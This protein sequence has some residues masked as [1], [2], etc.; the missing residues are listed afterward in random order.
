MGCLFF[1]GILFHNS[2]Q[3]QETVSTQSREAL[4]TQASHLYQQ[5]QFQVAQVM[6]TSLKQNSPKEDEIWLMSNYFGLICNLE[7]ERPQAAEKLASF[8]EKNPV[9][10]FRTEAEL[11][12][13]IEAYEKSDYPN[14]IGWFT[15]LDTLS[16]T[17]E[18]KPA[19]HYYVGYSFFKMD[20]LQKAKLSFQKIYHIESDYQA[21]AIYYYSL[22]SYWDNHLQN[23]LE[24]FEKLL[25]EFDYDELL[26]FYIVNIK[27]K[28]KKYNLALEEALDLIEKVKAKKEAE[29]LA[30][31]EARK[32]NRKKKKAKKKKRRKRTRKKNKSSGFAITDLELIAGQCYYNLEEYQKAVSYLKNQK[33]KN[34]YRQAILN[35]QLGTSFFHLK[36][37]KSALT[38][39]KKLGDQYDHFSQQAYYMMGHS[40]IKQAKKK[41]A[42]K[43]FRLAVKLGADST[44]IEEAKYN[45][46]KLSY[47]VGNPYEPV[48]DLIKKYITEHPDSPYRNEMRNMLL[49]H[50]MSTQDYYKSLKSLEKF[51]TLDLEEKIAYQRLLFHYGIELYQQAQLDSALVYLTKV[52]LMKLYSDYNDQ[53]G[54]WIGDILMQKNKDYDA[55]SYF[56]SYLQ[57]A[58]V[59]A[60]ELYEYAQYNIG[61]IYFKKKDYKKA[62]KAFD[63]FI[64]TAK[65]EKLRNDALLRSADSKFVL[66]QYRQAIRTYQK[67]GQL[68]IA[69]SD[70]AYYQMALCY[71]LLNKSKSQI[72]SLQTLA[73][74]FKRSRYREKVL[75][76]LAEVLG[77]K[78]R[79]RE[80]V[81]YYKNLIDDYPTGRYSER[82][83]LQMAM[84]M[85]NQNKLKDA[86]V[87]LKQIVSEKQNTANRKQAL[88]L[89]KK[90]YLLQNRISEY[91]TWVKSNQEVQ[92]NM[93][94]LDSAAYE[95]LE[96]NYLSQ[97]YQLVLEGADQYLKNFPKG[98][99]IPTVLDYATTSAGRLQNDSLI[100]KYNLLYDSLQTVIS[101]EVLSE[102][103]RILLSQ[104][105]YPKAKLYLQ[106]I[107]DSIQN[108]EL[109]SVSLVNLMVIAE[110]EKDTT[111]Q[112]KYAKRLIAQKDPPPKPLEKA[113]WLLARKAYKQK[114]TAQYTHYYNILE[115]ANNP[116]YRAE[117]LYAKILQL[118]QKGRYEQSSEIVFKLAEEI[119][120][121][122]LWGA[123]AL[124][125]LAKNYLEQ[126]DLYQAKYTIESVLDNF[127]DE[128]VLKQA[129]YVQ[130]LIKTRQQKA[131]D[132][133]TRDSLQNAKPYLSKEAIQQNVNS[134][135]QTK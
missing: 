40:Y 43:Q 8:L 50:L 59:Y 67:I 83:K 90:I 53:V 135:T 58:G 55:L 56:E 110:K 72:K 123:K 79:H 17:S 87:V 18:Q 62:I 42:L 36:N 92:I 103:T 106:K 117:A 6:F 38:Y 66:K 70:Y 88:L 51:Q 14:A 13:A 109:V 133:K 77:I 98:G 96:K 75:F 91:V 78:K 61:Y 28:Q 82:A 9:L 89:I 69:K 3:A 74:N 104:K 25:L 81:R 49:N 68:K 124:V 84:A 120:E 23:A 100:L 2:L 113:Y 121:Q 128:K 15:N 48:S 130:S 95:T 86:L 29:K 132:L 115:N 24:G 32:K 31:K 30:A 57:T 20:S 27:F 71:S 19:Y 105:S 4:Y 131:S 10:M 85:F 12:L 33:S 118:H 7:L 80:S 111:N 129:K 114:D 60:S 21:D 125:I 108:D 39:L 116:S 16:L 45:Y 26:Q 102:I 37:Y 64:I 126:K 52:E 122:T 76:E 101:E 22:I 93:S 73:D 44:L 35:Y 127:T 119:P 5:K 65:N 97:K 54:Y 107:V 112:L 47:E 99:M 94:A 41:A 11:A 34:T 46:L 134:K 63:Q 1:L